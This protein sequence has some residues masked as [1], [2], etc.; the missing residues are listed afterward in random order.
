MNRKNRWKRLL[1]ALTCTLVLIQS[2]AV[3]VPVYAA[4]KKKEEALSDR[5]LKD[6]PTAWDL[7][8][9][10]EDEDAFEADMKRL[11]ELIPEIEALRG[12]LDS[13]EGI[14]SDVENEDLQEITAILDK[15]EMYTAFL[16]SLDATDKWTGQATA[17]YH[18][19][20]QKISLAYAFEEPEIMEL[21]LKDRR[22]IFSDER[23]APYAY[24]MRK[25]TDPYFVSLG[26]EAKTVETLMKSAFNNQNTRNIFDYVEL[27]KLTFTYPDGTEGILT[28][29]T[30]SQITQN[31]E[32]DHEFRKEIYGLRNSMRQPYA[33]TY[34][35]LL[36]GAMKENWARSQVHGFSSSLEEAL[37]ENDV[38]P[39]IYDRTIEFAHSLL[40]KV[41][42]YYEARKEA[43]DLDEMMLCDLYIPVTDYEPKEVTYEEAVNAGRKGISIWGDEYLET[44]DNII[45]KPHIDVFPT[46]TKESGAFEYL[47]GNETTPFVM[48]NFDGLESYISTIVHE[49]GHAVYSEM[50]AENQNV[51]NNCPTIFTQEVASTANEIMF[52][53]A[54]I[55]DAKDD[56]EKL[57]WLDK[58]INLFLSTILTQCMY[59]EFEDYCYKTIEN[60]GSL[61]ASDMAEKWIELQ[62]TYYGD[63]FTVYDD[64]GIGWARIPHLYYDYYV[65]KYASSLT[66]AAS[67][68]EKVEDEG[69]DEID[70]Y[71][72]FLK[73]GNSADPASL[74]EIAGVDPLDD[75]TYE[76][77][78]EL[79][80]DLIDEYIEAL[81][82]SKR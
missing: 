5:V 14:L 48:F 11:E 47:K 36:E 30:F 20:A 60:G 13:V 19:V 29:E 69:Q 63:Q 68:C 53:K 80:S 22:E 71:L 4:P 1:S 66:Y 34:A 81:D 45:E 79:I 44:F 10:Y 64:S 16:S 37:Y 50:S 65:Y 49:M 21:P 59:S 15:A 26:E 54:K 57:Y 70:A 25:Y 67:I 8:D 77:A 9:L 32:Y 33:N 55:N 27:P 74:L 41:H 38:D 75:E 73:A 40:P 52:H 82:K 43:L 58:E 3:C 7:T 42:E 24:T 61:D 78:Q 35:S 51:Y 56:E 46:D 6:L 17:R 12:T 76:S 28:E 2:I 31:P 39:K 23:L 18:E 62:E 72:Q